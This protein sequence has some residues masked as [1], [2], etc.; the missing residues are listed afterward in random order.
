MSAQ[1][2]ELSANLRHF[3]ELPEQRGVCQII[4]ETEHCFDPHR[5]LGRRYRWSG[6]WA[7]SVFMLLL[8][9]VDYLRGLFESRDFII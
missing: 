4:P 1:F 8:R 9:V 6:E 7:F 2:V 5:R 3:V